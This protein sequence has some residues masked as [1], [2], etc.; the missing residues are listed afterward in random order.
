MLVEL[1]TEAV[2]VEALADRIAASGT[3]V[4]ALSIR[5][6]GSM[7]RTPHR[8]LAERPFPITEHLL[9]FGYTLR[10]E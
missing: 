2:E 9:A 10:Y 4:E 8:P 5:E 1:G 7:G 6:A 3:P